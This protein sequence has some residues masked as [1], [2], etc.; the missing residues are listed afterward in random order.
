MK[1]KATAIPF[2][3]HRMKGFAKG[4]GALSF[5]MRIMIGYSHSRGAGHDGHSLINKY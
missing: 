2:P 1:N 3:V 5:Q 4:N